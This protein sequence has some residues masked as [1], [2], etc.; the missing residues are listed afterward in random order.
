MS[1]DPLELPPF[2]ASPYFPTAADQAELLAE[3]FETGEAGFIAAALRTVAK[4]RGMSR[5]AEEAGI[6]R[7][8]LHKA[9]SERG[10]PK[11][12]TLL[13]VARALGFRMTMV[14]VAAE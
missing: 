12:S 3:A 11:L 1:I 2:D 10:D 7:E 5:V 14:P 9:L 4:A 6:T 13:G 8:G